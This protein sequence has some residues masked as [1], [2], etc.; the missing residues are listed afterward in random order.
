MWI[1]CCLT[2]SSPSILSWRTVIRGWVAAE[3]VQVSSI[4]PHVSAGGT[5][6]SQSAPRRH[7]RRR[8]A[9]QVSIMNCMIPYGMRC[10]FWTIFLCYCCSRNDSDHKAEGKSDVRVSETQWNNWWGLKSS[11]LSRRLQHNGH[12]FCSFTG[13]ISP[14]IPLLIY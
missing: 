6:P 1:I 8:A 7:H 12:L 13:Q 5:T 4:R 10:L 3:G 9:P 2:S 14:D 11:K